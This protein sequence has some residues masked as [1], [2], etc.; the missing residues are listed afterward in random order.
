MLSK[1]TFGECFIHQEKK[2]PHTRKRVDF[3]S[4]VVA[5]AQFCPA[6]SYHRDCACSAVHN[7]SS[8]IMGHGML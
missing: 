7:L 5:D 6:C 1:H 3:K 4:G 8:E 2:I